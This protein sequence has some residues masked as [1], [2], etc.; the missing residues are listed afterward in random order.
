MKPETAPI[1]DDEWLLRRVRIERFRSDKTPFVSPNAFEPRIRG[2]DIDH[3]GISL[4]R[5]ACLSSA[6]EILVSVSEEKRHEC[7]IVRIPVTFLAKLNLTVESRPDA[8]I[9][10]HV[11]IPEINANSYEKDKGS[12]IPLLLRIAEIASLEENIVLRPT[13]LP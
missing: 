12:F 13:A 9:R 1:S 10:G 3:D 5:Q 8:R 7:G 6:E 2:R 11:I 4:Y